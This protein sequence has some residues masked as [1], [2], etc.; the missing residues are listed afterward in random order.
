MQTVLASTVLRSN[1]LRR[2]QS[3]VLEVLACLPLGWGLECRNKRQVTF[4]PGKFKVEQGRRANAMIFCVAKG[5]HSRKGARR[6]P[7]RVRKGWMGSR[8]SEPLCREPLPGPALRS[9]WEC[10]HGGNR[11]NISGKGNA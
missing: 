8:T 2:R 10:G 7:A 9:A 6:P 11:N 1:S 4:C 3:I 5:K